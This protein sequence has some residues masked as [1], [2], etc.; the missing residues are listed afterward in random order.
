M[1]NPLTIDKHRML[2]LKMGRFIREQRIKVFQEDIATFSE[3]L[4][5]HTSLKFSNKDVE[6]MENGDGSIPID[7]WL[8]AWQLMQV[9]DKVVDASKC[10]S[11][12]FLASAERLNLSES[13]ILKNT[14]K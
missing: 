14:P 3:R 10:D 13:D 6:K 2:L 8:A 7:L 1:P 11:T 9:A 4:T 5:A 12:L